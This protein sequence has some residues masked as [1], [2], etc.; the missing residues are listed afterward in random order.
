MGGEQGGRRQGR[1]AIVSETCGHLGGQAE[2]E[3]SP[4]SAEWPCIATG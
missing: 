2:N 1:G 4:C 3:E